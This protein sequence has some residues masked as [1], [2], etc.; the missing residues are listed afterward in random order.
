MHIEI[1]G[2]AGPIGYSKGHLN[3]KRFVARGYIRQDKTKKV[4]LQ[5]MHQWQRIKGYPK[6]TERERVQSVTGYPRPE[7]AQLP[8]NETEN[9]RAPPN[10]REFESEAE[11]ACSILIGWS[12]ASPSILR[13]NECAA[14][15]DHE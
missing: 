6:V 4:D 15:S 1:E 8:L 13:V 5:R 2:L 14:L 11:T 10:E 9:A 12:M 7:L 3:R